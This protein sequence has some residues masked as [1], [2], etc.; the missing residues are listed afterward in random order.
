[1]RLPCMTK[2]RAEFTFFFLFFPIT[3]IQMK[4]VH[5]VFLTK[6]SNQTIFPMT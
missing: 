2:L 3:Q 1:M 5:E 4:T 6:K